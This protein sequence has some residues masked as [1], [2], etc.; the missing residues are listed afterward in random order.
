MARARRMDDVA[1]KEGDGFSARF[2]DRE[3][4]FVSEKGPNARMRRCTSFAL[5]AR[6]DAQLLEIGNDLSEA[7]LCQSWMLV[8]EAGGRANFGSV[9]GQRIVQKQ[10]LV[11][12]WSQ[13]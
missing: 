7:L 13:R 11:E 4:C 8:L 9:Q 10:L 2:V 3:T 1:M 5:V 6:P 12:V